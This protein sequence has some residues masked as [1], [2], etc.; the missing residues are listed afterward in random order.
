MGKTQVEITSENQKSRRQWQEAGV[1]KLLMWTKAFIYLSSLEPQAHN[2]LRNSAWNLPY[3][4]SFSFC[5]Y[6]L[7]LK[8]AAFLKIKLSLRDLG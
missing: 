1:T 6:P 7:F 5:N 8:K 2:Y 3:K 4:C